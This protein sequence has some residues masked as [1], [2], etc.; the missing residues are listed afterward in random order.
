M[1]LVSPQAEKDG[2]NLKNFKVEV[3]LLKTDARLKPG[4]TARVDGLLDSRKKVLKLALSGVFEEGG[5][6]FGYV[7]DGGKAPVK[8]PL[9][10][11]LRSEMDVEVLE[12]VK[13][14]DKLL[15]EKPDDKPKS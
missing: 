14:G 11:G 1:T 3:T 7:A 4:M 15:T 12:G 6:E 2:N 13:E 10:L 8:T 5:K 9:K